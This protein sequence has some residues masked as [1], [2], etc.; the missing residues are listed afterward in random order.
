MISASSTAN[1]L[2]PAPRCPPSPRLGSRREHDVTAS[3]Y[4]A[5]H[6]H[7]LV[8]LGTSAT[9]NAARPTKRHRRPSGAPPPL[10]RNIGRTGKVWLMGAAFVLGWII[11]ASFSDWA[12]R[13]TDRTDAAV[14]RQFVRIR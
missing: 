12:M 13:I 8:D 2:L 9:P 10:P 5:P 6:D 7:L 1:S 11:F 14:L 3:Q 4:A